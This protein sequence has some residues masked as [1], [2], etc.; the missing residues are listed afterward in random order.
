MGSIEKLLWLA[1]LVLTA[2]TFR[3]KLL[4]YTDYAG[5]RPPVYAAAPPPAIEKTNAHA[6]TGRSP[7]HRSGRD[8]ASSELSSTTTV[9]VVVPPPRFPD[10]TEV[11]PGMTGGDLRLHYGEPAIRTMKADNGEVSERY[12]YLDKETN[13][14]TVANLQGGVVVGAESKRQ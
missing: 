9:E 14:I 4:A 3:D 13:R 1:L 6:K 5:A 12:F 11:K 10:P 2:W 7:T 8:A